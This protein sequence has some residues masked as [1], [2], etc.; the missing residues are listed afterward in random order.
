MVKEIRFR[1]T[2]RTEEADSPSAQGGWGL[3]GPSLARLAD[4][5][6][7]HRREAGGVRL[8]S[9]AGFVYKAQALLQGPPFF[10]E[11]NG[12]LERSVVVRVGE[13]GD[14]GETRV[15]YVESGEKFRRGK[16]LTVFR[17]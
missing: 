16:L 4:S 14:P 8:V 2:S 15:Y 10:I 1:Q 9:R 5:L 6:V 13:A 3:E 12:E 7:H 11:L 17:G